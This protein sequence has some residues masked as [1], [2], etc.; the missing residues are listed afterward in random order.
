M[1]IRLLT[2]ED[3]K[4]H[5]KVSSSAFIWPVD[6]EKESIDTPKNDILGAF[7]DD[8]KT[9]M[10]DLEIYEFENIY[11]GKYLKSNGIGGVASMP[12]FRRKGAVRELFKHLFSIS[13]EKGW[14]ISTL[15][16]FSNYYYRQFGYDMVMRNVSLSVAFSNLSHFERCCDVKLYT[17]DN[18][19][20]LLSVYQTY[21]NKFNMMFKRIDDSRFYTKAFEKNEYTY[22][23][24]DSNGKC[25]SYVSYQVNRPAN[26]LDVKEIIYTSKESLLGILGFLRT[27]DGNLKNINFQHLPETS[28][29]P[30]LIGEYNAIDCRLS[31]GAASRILDLEAVLQSNTYPYSAGSF[32]LL[33]KDTITSN[34]GIFKVEYEKGKALITRMKKG[35]YD[36]ALTPAAASRIILSGEGYD[37]YRA[38]FINGVEIK[39]KAT[40]FFKAFPKR[41]VDL[42]DGF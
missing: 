27:Y 22:L 10:A 17:D 39:T 25:G 6:W 30:D 34:A 35:E 18:L 7:C 9:L 42:H 36:I 3:I 23:W 31:H 40:D 16:P 14:T 21:A 5:I 33:S 32:S 37:Y 38:S 24:Y 4:E 26:S 13:N 15:Y 11:C 8:N 41:E 2:Q 19:D 29:I 12:E 1:I 28:P 20:D